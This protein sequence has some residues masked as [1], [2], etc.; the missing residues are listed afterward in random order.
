MVAQIWH[1]PKNATEKSPRPIA[2]GSLVWN[3]GY[4]SSGTTEVV[5]PTAEPAA[6][7]IPAAVWLFGSRLLGLLRIGQ[8]R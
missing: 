6:V 5:V 3:V 4:L 7:P 2:A 8:R 1:Q